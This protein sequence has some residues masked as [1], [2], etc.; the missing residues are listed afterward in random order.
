MDLPLWGWGVL[1]MVLAGLLLMASGI[2]LVRRQ[3]ASPEARAFARELMQ[4]GEF[5]PWQAL[6]DELCREV[7]ADEDPQQLQRLFERH[8]F[9]FNHLHEFRHQASHDLV[10]QCIEALFPEQG[11]AAVRAELAHYR[12]ADPALDDGRV[13]LDILYLS[14]GDFHSLPVLVTEASRDVRGVLAR[15]EG[16]RSLRALTSV[17]PKL[18]GELSAALK[19]EIRREVTAGA[20]EDLRLFVGWL[21]RTLPER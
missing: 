13:L 11:V 14:E 15:A 6:A 5:R 2:R 3:P 8:G 17:Q 4:G 21:R 1:G 10:D 9:E 12:S 20:H 7:F 16:T 19:D 18:H